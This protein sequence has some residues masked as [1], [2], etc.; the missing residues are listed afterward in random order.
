M[1]NKVVNLILSCNLKLSDRGKNL[2]LRSKYLKYKVKPYLVVAGSGTSV[3]NISCAK[4]LNKFK[5]LQSLKY[6]LRA[7]REGIG[8]VFKDISKDKVF[9][10][11]LVICLYSIHCGMALCAQSKCSLLY[12]LLLLFAESTGIYHYCVNFQILFIF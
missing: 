11:L 9:D 5:N 12:S 8:G 10:S 1:F 3:G 2:N 4:F 7:Y 6:S